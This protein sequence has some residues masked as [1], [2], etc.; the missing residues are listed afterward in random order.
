MKNDGVRQVGKVNYFFFQ[1]E[2]GIRDVAVTGVQTCALPIYRGGRG[3]R[4]CAHSRAQRTS[5]RR[6]A[7]TPRVP[8]PPAALI[9]PRVPAHAAAPPAQTTTLATRD[10]RA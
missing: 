9:C 8:E 10:P 3:L 2:D 1:A 7:E 4:R 6:R 5:A